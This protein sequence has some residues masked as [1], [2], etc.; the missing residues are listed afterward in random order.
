MRPGLWLPERRPLGRHIRGSGPWAEATR[1]SAAGGTGTERGGRAPPSAIRRLH[2][3]SRLAAPSLQH[4]VGG[5][6]PST[7][8]GD[9]WFLRRSMM[10]PAKG[11]AA[12]ALL[13][14][15]VS[16]SPC[17]RTATGDVSRSR[18][19]PRRTGCCREDRVERDALRAP[20]LD[21]RLHCRRGRVF[22]HAEPLCRWTQSSALSRASVRDRSGA[23]DASS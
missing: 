7:T 12:A 23:C 18:P 10:E 4:A 3:C 1:P 9:A 19:R 2:F 20:G 13:R 16:A 15:P 8:A 21:G 22:T 6:A 11:M 17:R 5:Q 14:E